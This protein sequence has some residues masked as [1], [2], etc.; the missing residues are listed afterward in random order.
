MI[1]FM[2]YNIYFLHACFILYNLAIFVLHNIVFNVLSD[3]NICCYTNCCSIYRLG[4]NI[5]TTLSHPTHTQ[6]LIH[7]HIT[8]IQNTDTLHTQTTHIYTIHTH[9]TNIYTTPIQP[10]THIPTHQY[11]YTSHKTL[12]TSC[13]H[14][15]TTHPTHPT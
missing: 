3:N 15:H 12:N 10:H 2:F 4:W 7:T 6:H 11:T 14:M 1:I 5:Y 13:K 9:C 8:H